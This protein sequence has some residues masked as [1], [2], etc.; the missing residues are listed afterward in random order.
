MHKTWIRSLGQE[1]S[2]EQEMV[3]HTSVLAWEIPRTEEPGS[4]GFTRVG[5][6]LATKSLY[7]LEF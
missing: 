5:H 3:T 6:D 4:L 7:V 2:L 1:D